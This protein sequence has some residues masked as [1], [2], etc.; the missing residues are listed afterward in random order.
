M[1]SPLCLFLLLVIGQEVD[2]AG[3]SKAQVKTPPPKQTTSSAPKR[4]EDDD[5]DVVRIN[6]TLVTV[7]VSVMDRNG[8]YILDLQ[9]EDFEIYENGTKQE[10]A[11]F[12]PTEKPFT[13]ALLLDISDSMRFRISDIQ[14]AA[15]SFINQ[16][17]PTDRVLVIAFDSQIR[18][19]TELTTNHDAARDAIRRTTL[20][21]GTRV[22]DS[23]D[24]VVNQRLK[25]IN[26]RKALILF[27]DGVDT[28]SFQASLKDNTRLAE[29]SDVLIYPIQYSSAKNFNDQLRG[30]LGSAGSGPTMV[31]TGPRGAN[32]VD[33]ARASSY[34][35]A[36]AEKT[37]ARLYRVDDAEDL[38]RSFIRIAGE[39]RQQY[40]LSYYPIDRA[41][42]GSRKIKVR[43]ARPQVAVR[44]RD[45]YVFR[46]STSPTKPR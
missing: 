11:N 25:E 3:V 46:P 16:L 23:I 42:A 45:N 21:A 15:T 14:Q 22:Y 35:N 33:A 28:G 44:A 8:K 40:T 4:N 30:G 38:T 27:T 39:L 6:T 32:N 36:L 17:R 37:G 10:I 7:P 24:F 2:G 34:L 13:I 9:R 12:D 29:E 26:G 1:I 20:G 43:V 5:V 41:Q 19:L 31:P 18:I